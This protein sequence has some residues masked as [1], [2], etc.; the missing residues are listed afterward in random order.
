MTD[1]GRMTEEALAYAS[2]ADTVVIESNYD[3]D[4]L[5]G[6]PY[7]HEL[8]MRICQGHGHLSND[9]CAAAREVHLVT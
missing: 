5:M 2:E 6:G 7:P 1:L 9:E 8:K 4:M 3:V